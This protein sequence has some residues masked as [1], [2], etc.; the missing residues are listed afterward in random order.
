MYETSANQIGKRTPS[1]CDM[2][3][4][5][6]GNTQTFSKSFAG[7]P[8]ARGLITSVTRSKVHKLLDDF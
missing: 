4:V 1:Q 3:D 5:Y 6:R 8:Q 7:P 2:P